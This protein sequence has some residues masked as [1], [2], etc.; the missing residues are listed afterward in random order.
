MLLTA[1][2][3]ATF[4]A[5]WQRWWPACH[6]GR[7]DVARCVRLQDHEYDYLVPSDPWT[8][9]GGAAELG[10]IGLI[11]LAGAA[12]LLPLALVPPS[13]RVLRSLVALVPAASLALVRAQ[14]FLSGRA[15]HVVGVPFL[16]WAVAVW[17]LAW[18]FALTM[19]AGAQLLRQPG[20]RSR[21]DLASALLVAGATPLPTLLIL[22]PA[23]AS[24]SSYDTAPWSE[25]VTAPLLLLA[26]ATLWIPAAT[27]RVM[28]LSGAVSDRRT[29]RPGDLG[30]VR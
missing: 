2:A 6:R 29:S 7:F 24:Y 28:S 18:P 20:G 8:P 14:T 13:H 10:G 19:W 15:G 3:S 30:G 21:G 22:G 12:L 11:L 16:P 27:E 23:A 26:A 25:A 4:A 17:L 5:A 9:V 1:S